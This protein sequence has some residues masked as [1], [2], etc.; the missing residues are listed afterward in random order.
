MAKPGAISRAHAIVSL[1]SM[2]SHTRPSAG[3]LYPPGDPRVGVCGAPGPG[4]WLPTQR[5]K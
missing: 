4:P 1:C 3:R 5:P 2:N